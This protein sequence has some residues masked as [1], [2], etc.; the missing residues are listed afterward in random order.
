MIGKTISHYTVLEKLGERGMGV[1]Y[2]AEDTRLKRT[3]ALKFLT[4]H[5]IGS[6]KERDRFIHEAQSA[7]ALDH[8]SI[9]TVHEIDTAHGRTFIAMAYVAG[10]SL[11]THIEKGPLKVDEALRLT[12]DLCGALGESHSKDVVHRDIKP[13]NVIVSEKGHA[14][15]LD[16][17]LAMLKGR[18]RLTRE[19]TTVGTV[20]YM[21]PEQA[22]GD[23]VDRRTDI[24]SLGVVLYQM[25][26]GQLPFKGDHESAVVYS[27]LNE[28][29]E[30]VTALRTGVPMELERII[31]KALAKSPTERYQNIDDMRVDL[32]NL[33]KAMSSSTASA[34]RGG[35]R[36]ARSRTRSEL[37]GRNGFKRVAGFIL[38]AIVVFV[39]IWM[40]PRVVGKDGGEPAGPVDHVTG[41]L[42]KNRQNSIAV[43]PLA[44][45]SGDEENEFFADGMT[46]EIITQLAQISALKVI[47]RTSVMR[48]KD[49]DL[50]ITAIAEELNVAKILEG[51]VLWAGDRV[52]IN[53]QLIDGATDE[54]LWAKSYESGLNDVLGLQRRVANDVA[55]EIKVE[56][57]DREAINLATSPTVNKDAYEL[58]L[59]GRFWWNKRT[60]ADVRKAI[61]H[62]LEA[63]QVD[64]DYALAYAGLGECYLVLGTWDQLTPPTEIYPKAREYAERALRIDPNLGTAHAV[65]GGVA[66]EYDWDWDVAENEYKRALDINPN[67]AV[68]H[69]WYAEF[70]TRMGRF[71]EAVQH[72][73]TARE[74]DPLSLVIIAVAVYI[75]AY[76]GN[77]ERSMQAIAEGIEIDPDYPALFHTMTMAYLIWGEMDEAVENRLRYLELTSN[78]G[79]ER[80]VVAALEQA[81]ERGGWRDFMRASLGYLKNYYA[82]GYAPPTLIAGYHAMLG[83]PDSSMAWLERGYRRHDPWMNSITLYPFYRSLHTNPRFIALA[84][85][86]QLDHLLNSN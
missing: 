83:E 5:L 21:S 66:D 47:S 37:P 33:G 82:A 34:G 14:V 79:I 84:K 61:G 38:I 62:Y 20:N 46:E 73:E 17:G 31:T 35:A 54:H 45:L 25:I 3:V 52:R 36:G 19:G 11:E 80:E 28:N 64:P 40:Y 58:Y 23:A 30:P 65:L 49:T 27:I 1:V 10:E 18:T 76:D 13:A 67:D 81:F 42:L 26:T 48:F 85:R 22:K 77:E 7:A 71:D 74:L 60:T 32:V 39:A 78:T 41:S 29:P 57:T 59:K 50:P 12:L 75:H 51:S 24:W 2:K 4:P 43:L 56:L 53:A 9:C 15:I 44:N 63:L 86:L 8:P 72:I 16:F 6:D 68:A 55:R 69:Q 70:L